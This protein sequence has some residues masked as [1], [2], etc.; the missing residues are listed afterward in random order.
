[1]KRVPSF[2]GA[3]TLFGCGSFVADLS[4]IFSSRG[5]FRAVGKNGFLFGCVYPE[6]R[7]I[8]TILFPSFITECRI[9]EYLFKF[10]AECKLLLGTVKTVNLYRF[11]Y[12]FDT[13]ICAFSDFQHL[14]I[15]T[16][17]RFSISFYRNLINTAAG[18][19]REIFRCFFIFHGFSIIFIFSTSA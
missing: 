3:E 15:S 6:S 2:F 10:F 13:W 9:F 1:M 14:N 16:V 12:F 4:V 5:I 7:L 17:Q 18:T 8:L 19:G 11:I